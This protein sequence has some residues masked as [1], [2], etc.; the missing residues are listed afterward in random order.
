MDI[1][2]K[3][4]TGAALILVGILLVNMVKS[5]RKASSFK[6][7]TKIPSFRALAGI[8]LIVGIPY[9]CIQLFAK[10]PTFNTIKEEIA[11]A[12]KY[13]QFDR[14][15]HGYFHLV[16]RNPEDTYLH[17]QMLEAQDEFNKLITKSWSVEIEDIRN[18]GFNQVIKDYYS[19]LKKSPDSK[20]RDIAHIFY[21]IHYTNLNELFFVNEYLSKVTD[22]NQRYYHYALGKYH[23]QR[24]DYGGF[25]AGE[26][27][28]RKEIAL[29]GY[30]SGSYEVLAR[31]YYFYEEDEKLTK[32]L[33]EKAAN[34]HFP[35]YIKRIA[36]MR[37]MD[38]PGYAETVIK[39]KWNQL[40]WWG[41][42]SALL[43]TIIWIIYLRRVDVYEPEKWKYIIAT[44]LM[45]CCTIFFIYP[46][47]DVMWDVYHFL[48]SDDIVTDLAYDIIM[49]GANEELVKII[50]VFILLLFKKGINEPFDYIFY[51]SV[52]ALGFAFVENIGYIQ[53]S[54]LYNIN[55]RAL[56]AAVGH[57]T[58]SSVVGYGLMLGK[59]SKHTHPLLLFGTFF[60]IA[61][62]MHGFYD[63]WLM[64]EW[65]SQYEWVTLCFFIL[66][67]HFWFIMKNNTL[68]ISNFYDP[69][70][71]IDNDK[72]KYSLIL[73]LLFIFMYSY[74]INA[75]TRGPNYG[76]AMMKAQL[77]PYGYLILYLAF[78]FSRYEIIR[79]YLAPLNVPLTLLVPQPIKYENLTGMPVHI[80]KSKRL[81]LRREYTSFEKHL[82]INSVLGQKVVLSTNV[83]YVVQMPWPLAYQKVKKNQVVIV[84]RLGERKLSDY[85]S[86]VVNLYMVP[87][88]LDY[89][90]PILKTE[91]FILVGKVISKRI[92][93]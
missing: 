1:L 4:L 15:A 44:F 62:V 67:I 36:Y 76:D 63:F 29:K 18:E 56:M 75:F 19:Q 7:I 71:K 13:G 11:Y 45:A 17:L 23:Y 54:E 14:V 58:F 32:L 41:F 93:E 64:N 55:A 77:L 47:D 43:I 22:K 20:L 3:I 83:G 50:P 90:K 88:G 69:K 42:F 39:R 21:S 53:N 87:E 80:F 49:I 51:S 70:V 74:T 60:A 12:K 26:N 52:S 59:Y 89:D 86:I 10:T 27:A 9:L 85:E 38:V 37:V 46:I 48:P 5:I 31:H 57:M 84:P 6:S 33:Y 66:T 68:N 65:A 2:F 25:T 35:T 40:S 8:I 24:H 92:A 61:A 30:I 91:D 81:L 34:P 72:L 78:S 79:G 16:Q 28:L 82:P 73:S